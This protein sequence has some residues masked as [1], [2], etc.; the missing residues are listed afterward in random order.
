[1]SNQYGL[2]QIVTDGLDFCVDANA[3]SSYPARNFVSAKV[4]SVYNGGARSANYTVQYSDD[5]SSWTTAF[6][7]V[8]SNQYTTPYTSCGIKINS[9]LGDG[10]YGS[11]QYWRYVE[12]SAVISHHPRVSR[13]I[14]TDAQGLDYNFKVYV[15]DN[16]SDS[17]TYL[18]GTVSVDVGGATWINTTGGTNVTLTHAPVFNNAGYFD[19]DGTNDYAATAASLDFDDNWTMEMWL[20]ADS[21]T[22]PSSPCGNNRAG[23]WEEG[24]SYTNV[25]G[26]ESHASG[27]YFLIC[28]G[29]VGCTDATMYSESVLNKWLH[30]V[31]SWEDTSYFRTYVNGVAGNTVDVSSKDM[32][33]T[34]NMGICNSVKHCGL[35]RCNGRVAVIR[36]YTRALSAAEVKQNFEAQR[37][38]FKV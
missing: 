32:T 21:W 27:L 2:A 16:C 19:F 29:G 7:G 36:H 4:Y 6:G 22:Y 25:V 8:C 35:A 1:M 26:L 37:S 24:Q 13:I 34:G 28:Y 14:L 31:G 30:V 11:H 10:S 17:G 3:T 9:G 12:G 18:V 5:N 38:R 15:A 20:N 23:W 33:I